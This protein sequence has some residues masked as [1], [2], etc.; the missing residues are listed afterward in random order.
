MSVD[1]YWREKIE[2]FVLVLMDIEPFKQ[3]DNSEEKVV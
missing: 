1:R 3:N 2:L